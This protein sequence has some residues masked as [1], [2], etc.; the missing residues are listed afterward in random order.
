MTFPIL[1][2][3]GPP[4]A[5]KSTLIAALVARH[6]VNVIYF[7]AHEQ[8]TDRSPAEISDWIARGMPLAETLP[9]NLI[10]HLQ[11]AA[12]DAPVLFETPMGRAVPEHSSLIT[13]SVWLDLPP[14]IALA[15]KIAATLGC[16]EWG[17]LDELS[18]WLQGYLANYPLIISPSLVMQTA[19]VRHLADEILDANLAP[20]RLEEQLSARMHNLQMCP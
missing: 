2:I 13:W 8:M 11:D 17:S 19:R 1:A 15:R 18:D 12:Q 3:S 20:D 9:P 16:G 5:G 14:D 6:R 7:D 4:G 10:A